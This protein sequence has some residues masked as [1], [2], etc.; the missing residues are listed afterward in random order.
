MTANVKNGRQV[1]KTSIKY[2][3]ITWMTMFSSQLRMLYCAVTPVSSVGIL[4]PILT[5]QSRWQ[6]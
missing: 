4:A 5:R 3:Q 6:P 2:N 1:G